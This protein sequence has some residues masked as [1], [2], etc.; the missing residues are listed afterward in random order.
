MRLDQSIANRF[1]A[2]ELS[3][4]AAEIDVAR[5]SRFAAQ[6]EPD[7]S[8]DATAL[9]VAAV[10]RGRAAALL[11]ALAARAPDVDWAALPWPPAALAAL[12]DAL[13]RRLALDDL[14][15]LCLRLGVD[16]DSLPGEGKRARARELVLA[17]ERQSRTAEVS[18]A[19]SR[20]DAKNAKKR[21]GFLRFALF[22][23]SRAHL[24]PALLAALVLCLFALAGWRLGRRTLNTLIDAAPEGA[25]KS[26]RSI[27]EASGTPLVLRVPPRGR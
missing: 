4:I 23:S 26:I 2:A 10:D 11:A 14:R 8:G 1:D 21:R 6:P 3:A 17:M 20:E 13:D 16:Y 18:E 9:L 25:T 5:T 27:V 22:A 7:S 19:I 15:D 24:Q 12:H